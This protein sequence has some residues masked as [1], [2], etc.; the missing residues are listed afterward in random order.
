MGSSTHNNSSGKVF[1]PLT[2][3]VHSG[4]ERIL[5]RHGL[6]LIPVEL[7]TQPHEVPLYGQGSRILRKL[8]DNPLSR[9]LVREWENSCLELFDARRQ[10][11]VK[12]TL[13][14]QKVLSISY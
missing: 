12:R 1:P 7:V 8:F 6:K 3:S 14:V 5:P 4:D 10:W 11:N 2:P 13:K 9:V